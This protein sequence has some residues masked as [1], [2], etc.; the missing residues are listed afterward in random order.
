[1]AAKAAST[2][3]IKKTFVTQYPNNTSSML[4]QNE[5]QIQFHFE[6]V[7]FELKDIK[8]VRAWIQ[9]IIAAEQHELR[10]LNYVFCSDK[11]LHHINMEYLQHD[12]FTDIITFPLEESPLIE[13][14]IFISSE[15]VLENAAQ[16]GVDF[17]TELLRVIIHGVLHLCG[18]GDKTE[19]EKTAMRA[20]EDAC[21]GLYFN[22]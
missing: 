5:E 18:Y 9:Q 10:Q 7:D 19:D 15:R 2:V 4:E 8:K 13:S 16:F 12:T 3:F 20:K 17:Q 22:P 21:L 1:M 6:D 14:D 11:Y